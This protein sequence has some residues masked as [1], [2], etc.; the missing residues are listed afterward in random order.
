MNKLVKMTARE[1]TGVEKVAIL[2]AEIGPLFNEDYVAFEKK[3]NLSPDEM[4][5]IRMAMEGLEKY[6]PAMHGN[7]IGIAE[8]QRESSVLEE[9]LD[10][11]KRKGIFS[12]SENQKINSSF[13]KKD[14]T[15]GFAEIVKKDP[16][17]VA[18]V[19]SSWLS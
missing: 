19:L 15:N 18:K 3:L 9:L 12:P 10:Y 5:R 8:I 2:L 6:H 1:L 11:G 4:K 13:M 16:E 14:P 7:D 17:A